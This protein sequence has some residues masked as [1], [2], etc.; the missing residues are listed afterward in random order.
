MTAAAAAAAAV[1]LMSDRLYL[2]I[3]HDSHHH[4]SLTRFATPRSKLAC[5]K[6]ASSSF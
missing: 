5:Y 4:P 1:T 3:H 6:S 2:S